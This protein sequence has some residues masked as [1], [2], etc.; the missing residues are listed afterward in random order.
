MYM[1]IYDHLFVRKVCLQV[2]KRENE[3]KRREKDSK[4]KLIIL[5]LFERKIKEIQKEKRNKK[6][7]EEK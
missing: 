3:K 7:M 4:K 1:P 6:Y 5:T 2:L